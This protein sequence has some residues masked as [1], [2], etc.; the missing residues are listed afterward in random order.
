MK[1]GIFPKVFI[2]TTL[3]LFAV[4]AIAVG[5]FY[6]QFVA[7]YNAQQ[8]QQLVANY[9]E[10]YDD[11][12]TSGWDREQMIAI[13]QQFADTNQTFIFRIMG[14]DETT[15]FRTQ[16]RD[17]PPDGGTRMLFSLGEYTL[18]AE[19]T[20]PTLGDGDFVVT[21]AFAITAIMVVALIGAAFFARQ[22][23]I[24]IKRL[25]ADAQKMKELSPVEPTQQRNDELGDLYKDVHAMYAKLK[26]TILELEAENA[27]RKEM[28]EA[29]RYFFSAA[30]HELKTPIAAA[31][32][33][34]EGM[35]ADIGDYKNHPKYLSEC[36]KL[37]DE[38]SKTIYEILDIVNLDGNF[39]PQPEQIN[40]GD[41]VQTQAKMYAPMV[42]AYGV[43]IKIAMPSGAIC[44]VDPHLLKKVLSNIMLNAIQ[45]T[46]PGGCIH[47]FT[48]DVL[49][50]VRLCVLNPGCIN[51]EILPRLFDPFYRADSARSR[52]NGQTGLGLAIVKKTLDIFGA[53]F[54]LLNTD[55]GVLFW[56]DLPVS[57]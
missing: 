43:E 31:R 1:F 47:V 30:S 24:P 15:L 57:S 20:A 38:Q 27:R 17:A 11:L 50:A 37:M 6:Q 21:A 7:F 49:G 29:Q 39:E 13:A 19:N 14:E 4:V 10:L 5:L 8:Q 34:M 32:V 18:I 23:T 46:K 26:D 48:E 9:Q 35:L 33:V 55:D 42:G 45:N 40:I 22:M 28:E 52:K 3:F 41:I 12:R 2:Y 16:H 56:V 25:V 53:E 44:H 51:E 36:I 54:G